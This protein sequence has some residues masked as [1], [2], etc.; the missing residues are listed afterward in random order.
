MRRNIITYVVNKIHKITILIFILIIFIILIMIFNI[1]K[2][3]AASHGVYDEFYNTMIKKTGSFIVI[4]SVL[5][6]VKFVFNEIILSV[7][8][9]KFKRY[10]KGFIFLTFMIMP[11]FVLITI[12]NDATKGYI[13]GFKDLKYVILD[14]PLSKTEICIFTTVFTEKEKNYLKFLEISNSKPVFETETLSLNVPNGKYYS[15]GCNKKVGDV[16]KVRYLPN[17]NIM[18]DCV[19]ANYSVG[20]ENAIKMKESKLSISTDKGNRYG[21]YSTIAS[22]YHDNKEYNKAI[23]YY[24]KAIELIDEDTSC[25]WSIYNSRAECYNALCQYNNSINDYKNAIDV[26]NKSIDLSLINN[27]GEAYADVFRLQIAEK[28][29]KMGDYDSAI[30]E[31]KSIT[32]SKK[33]SQDEI[34]K[35]EDEKKDYKKLK[36]TSDT[37]AHKD[38]NYYLI[39]GQAWYN[40][41]F[42]EAGTENLSIAIESFVQDSYE[43]F[44][45]RGLCYYKLS[46]Y[47]KAIEDLNKALDY[48]PVDKKGNND[49]RN[50]VIE[51]LGDCYMGAKEYEKALGAYKNANYQNLKDKVKKAQKCVDEN[52]NFSNY[53]NNKQNLIEG[54]WNDVK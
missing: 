41:S 22:I 3:T 16:V 39:L 9:N 38:Y 27:A 6:A 21:E 44:Y 23:L 30:N 33:H 28:Y 47:D 42:Y 5:W 14:K 48:L 20:A 31:C 43:P 46:N 29:E 32:T 36:N 34:K 50:A 25:P 19:S 2:F 49:T 45:Y 13:N 1:L 18:L 40:K 17:T 37:Y 52:N 11:A 4:I 7:K 51:S 8:C 12:F 26:Y 35:A 10:I 24:S 15:N 53:K 54:D